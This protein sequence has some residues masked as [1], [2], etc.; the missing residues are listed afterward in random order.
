MRSCIVRAAMDE[1]KMSTL[2]PKSGFELPAAITGP[3]EYASSPRISLN[4]IA[5]SR[6]PI[7]DG[8]QCIDV[9]TLLFSLARNSR[10]STAS[11]LAHRTLKSFSN[12]DRLSRSEERRVG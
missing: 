1:L 12:L 2:G 4:L 11:Q 10:A 8:P 9:A 6:S 7:Q 5:T 3:M